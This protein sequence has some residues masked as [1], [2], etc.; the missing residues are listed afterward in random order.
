V[1]VQW[2]EVEITIAAATL[3]PI[4]QRVSTEW[5]MID[6]SLSLQRFA[7]QAVRFPWLLFIIA[8]LI[9]SPPKRMPA[10]RTTRNS[11]AVGF[12]P[13]PTPEGLCHRYFNFCRTDKEAGRRLRATAARTNHPKT[14]PHRKNL[15]NQA[16][17]LATIRN[18]A[19]KP[20]R[21]QSGGVFHLIWLS[22]P[23]SPYARR[24]CR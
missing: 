14:E 5:V 21:H 6:P 10:R 1:P 24:I 15:P 17:Q 11:A 20:K 18:R 19:D 22:W 13:T 9:C 3:V 23:I 8:S 2:V 7:T 4:A 12:E 16:T